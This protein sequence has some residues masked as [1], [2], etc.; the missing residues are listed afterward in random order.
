MID[1]KS[2]IREL[3]Y[4]NE[5]AVVLADDISR[6]VSYYLNDHAKPGDTKAALETLSQYI[7]KVL[8]VV[9]ILDPEVL[10]V[11]NPEKETTTE[12]PP[13]SP[14]MPLTAEEVEAAANP[15]KKDNGQKKDKYYFNEK[16]ELVIPG[17]DSETARRVLAAQRYMKVA[18]AVLR[19]VE[20]GN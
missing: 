10:A 12:E 1:N 20:S 13:C 16:G 7:T 11:A 17:G 5:G 19:E 3:M 6:I 8:D 9:T 15:A 4:G 2:R 14:R 18:E